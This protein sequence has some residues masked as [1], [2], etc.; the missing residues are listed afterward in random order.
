LH[1]YTP[2]EDFI[3]IFPGKEAVALMTDD[4]DET[5]NAQLV[6]EGLARDARWVSIDVLLSGMLTGNDVVELVATLYDSR[7]QLERLALA[8]SA[9]AHRWR[10]R[11]TIQTLF[12]HCIRTLRK[13]K[14]AGTR[15]SA[16]RIIRSFTTVQTAT[17]IPR[18]AGLGA[19][20]DGWLFGEYQSVVHLYFQ[21]ET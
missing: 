9:T 20:L 7:K 21:K 3:V 1:N 8:C 13:Q 11:M 10:R 17:S 2:V 18:A 6:A 14:F 4:S 12:R 15:F 19:G 5:V 16:F